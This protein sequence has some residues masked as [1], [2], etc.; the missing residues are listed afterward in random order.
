MRYPIHSNSWTFHLGEEIKVYCF[1]S[2][3]SEVVDDITGKPKENITADYIGKASITKSIEQCGSG[4][5][6]ICISIPQGEI[7]VCKNK[8]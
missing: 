1:N 5:K 3:I 4:P 2:S 7:E 6:R 8:Q